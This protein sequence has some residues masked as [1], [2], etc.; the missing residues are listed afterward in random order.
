[1]IVIEDV[2]LNAKELR[3]TTRAWP[4]LRWWLSSGLLWITACMLVTLA[5][6][7]RQP[8]PAALWIPLVQLVSLYGVIGLSFVIQRR[9]MAVARRAPAFGA[10]TTWRLDEQGVTLTAALVES[11]LDWRAIVRVAEEKDRLVLAVTPYNNPVLPLRLLSPD[12]LQAIRDLVETV[13]AS[14][15]LGRG[16]D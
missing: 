6:C 7:W 5:L 15:R 2:E 10:P 12:Q 13:R 3:P 16:V 9:V 11:R 4:G 1:M 14:G 8:G